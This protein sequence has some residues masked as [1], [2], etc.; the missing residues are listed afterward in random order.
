MWQLAVASSFVIQDVHRVPEHLD[1]IL[2][3]L[4][5]QLYTSKKPIVIFFVV[6][7]YL[8]TPIILKISTYKKD[9]AA[10]KWFFRH[11]RPKLR[12]VKTDQLSK[13]DRVTFFG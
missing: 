1:I 6:N 7:P 12:P 5:C 8:V 9:I 2:N 13:L 3:G 10:Q 4:R 11:R